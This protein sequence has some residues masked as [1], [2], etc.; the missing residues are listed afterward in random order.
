MPAQDKS[1]FHFRLMALTYA[2]RDLLHPR[3]E[4]LK[5]VGIRAGSRVLDFGCGPGSYVV[6]VAD[7]VGPS[8]KIYALDIRPLSLEMV[9][10]RAAKRHLANVVPVRSDG[11]TGLLDRSLDVILL[12]DVFHELEQPEAVLKELHRILKPD[13]VLSFSDHHLG[14]EEILS[15]VTKG[16]LFRLAKKGRRT[17]SFHRVD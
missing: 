7:L 10:K 3:A 2:W 1:N 15:G 12:Y 9:R 4:V 6:P 13:G 17:Y 5:E 14:E 8:G 11:Q 16:G